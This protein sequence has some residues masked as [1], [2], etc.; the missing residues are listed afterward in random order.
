MAK[1]LGA[2]KVTIRYQVTLPPEVRKLLEVKEGD[3]LVFAEE[4]G[5]VFIT[6]EVR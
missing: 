4:K 6:T 3:T 5:K 1:V 2:S